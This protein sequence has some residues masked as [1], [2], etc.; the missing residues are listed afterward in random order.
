MLISWRRWRPLFRVIMGI[1]RLL[2]GR[3][4][5]ASDINVGSCEKFANDVLERLGRPADVSVVEYA[6]FTGLPCADE[7]DQY[8]AGDIR[9]PGTWKRTPPAAY[10]VLNSN[11]GFGHGLG[12]ALAL[13]FPV[14]RDGIRRTRQPLWIIPQLCQCHGG[15][16][17][18]AVPRWMAQRF[19]QARTDEDRNGRRSEPEVPPGFLHLQTCWEVS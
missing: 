11:A 2:C 13:M 7:G 4:K 15:K 10:N 14:P 1:R 9:L 18:R 16:I 12:F 5:S 19:Q 8:Q 6:N 17:L 3:F